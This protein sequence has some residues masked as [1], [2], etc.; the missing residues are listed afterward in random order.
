MGLI[1]LLTPPCFSSGLH[2]GLSINGCSD[3]DGE[4][5]Y[6]LDGEELWYADFVN[7]RGVEPQPSFIDHISYPGAYEAAVADLQICRSNLNILQ[8]AYKDTPQE[9]GEDQ[10]TLTSC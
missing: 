4:V 1:C 10:H 7:K 2:E 9:L 5:M 3:S 6:S 8:R